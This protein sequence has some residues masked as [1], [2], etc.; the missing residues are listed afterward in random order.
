MYTANFLNP[1]DS[2]RAGHRVEFN[3]VV[4]EPVFPCRFVVGISVTP[5]LQIAST[6]VPGHLRTADM[7]GFA[8]APSDFSQAGLVLQAVSQC[9]PWKQAEIDDLDRTRRAGFGFLDEGLIDHR[10]VGIGI[11]HAEYAHRFISRGAS[12][13]INDVL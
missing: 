4:L 12:D 1:G 8:F 6:N 11:D 5:V 9:F 2:F 13:V 7:A 3:A 10:A